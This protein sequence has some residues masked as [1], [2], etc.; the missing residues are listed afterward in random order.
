MCK[1]KYN[2][3]MMKV[4]DVEVWRGCMMNNC[5]VGKTMAIMY[6]EEVCWLCTL[7]MYDEDVC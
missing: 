4:N 2:E 6:G 7:M 5:C 3:T 1:K